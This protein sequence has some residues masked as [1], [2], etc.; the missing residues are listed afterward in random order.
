LDVL[1]LA[2][3]QLIVENDQRRIA[4]RGHVP[5]LVDLALAEVGAGMRAVDGLHEL[6]DHERSSRVGELRKLLQVL[7]GRSTRAGSLSRRADED[8]PLSRGF[9]R[10]EL[11]A[12][13]LS[14][15]GAVPARLRIR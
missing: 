11:F 10:D 9:D 4:G 8:C 13:G 12:D 2:R 3:A 15:E 14:P 1:S 6:T 5:E 7:I